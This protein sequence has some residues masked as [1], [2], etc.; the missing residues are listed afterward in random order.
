MLTADRQ[1]E[2]LTVNTTC[3]DF[4]FVNYNEMRSI[5]A[6]KR[7]AFSRRGRDAAAR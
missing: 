4:G 1:Y 6:D 3:R 5:V 2:L 7:A